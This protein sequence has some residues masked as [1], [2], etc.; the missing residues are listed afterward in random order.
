VNGFSDDDLRTFADMISTVPPPS[1]MAYAVDQ[2]RMER[3][4]AL[5]R[6]YRCKV[7]HSPTSRVAMPCRGSQVSGKISSS[8]R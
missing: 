2:A 7:C 6:E 5:V 1:P 4:Q 3:G 8:R